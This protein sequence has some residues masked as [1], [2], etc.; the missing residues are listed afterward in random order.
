MHDKKLTMV[1]RMLGYP[2]RLFAFLSI[3][4]GLNS[5]YVMGEDS[6]NLNTLLPAPGAVTGLE[7]AEDPSTYDRGSLFEYINGGA[8]LY[9]SYRFERLIS[10]FYV[11]DGDEEKSIVLDIYDMATPLQA[12][13]V[14]GANKRT[15]ADRVPF[16]AEGYASDYLLTFYRGRY[17]VELNAGG[18]DK[19]LLDARRSA[20]AEVDKKIGG[21]AQPPEELKL[22]PPENQ[23]PGSLRYITGGVLG[24]GFIPRGLEADYETDG[25]R[26]KVSLAMFGNHDE[27]W[28]SYTTFKQHYS[29]RGQPPSETERDGRTIMAVKDPYRETVIATVEKHYLVIISDLPA[30]EAGFGLLKLVSGRL[31]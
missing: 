30:P 25:S 19:N 8:E 1:S 26:K 12:F 13:G 17:Y 3:I 14:F 24:H 22:L 27:A 5:I 16:G 7:L 4:A 15:E 10:A 20:A 6:S 18:L 31:H 23:V 9:L 2:C 29:G 28:K 21:T 11:L